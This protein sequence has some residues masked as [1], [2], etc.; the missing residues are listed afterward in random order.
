MGETLTAN[1]TID[2]ESHEILSYFMSWRFNPQRE[3]VCTTYATKAT[4]GVYEVE[5]EIPDV[6]R[7]GF[8]HP[9]AASTTRQLRVGP[10]VLYPPGL[11]NH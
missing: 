11:C 8:P 3:N 4:A 6:I 10:G 2:V 7:P 1:L 5:I 9:A